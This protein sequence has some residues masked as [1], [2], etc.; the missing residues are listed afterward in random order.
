MVLDKEW[1]PTGGSEG[2]LFIHGLYHDLNDALKRFGQFLALGN[3]PK[4]IRPFVFNWPSAT[5]PLL[6]WCAH[7]QA[8]DNDTH[9]DFKRFLKCLEV[10]GI[11]IL[12][13][14][15]HSLGARFFLRSFATTKSIFSRQPG[16]FLGSMLSDESEE[17][18]Q[19][20]RAQPSGINTE[21][22]N[23]RRIEL[24]NLIFLNPEYEF[25]TFVHDY[26]DVKPYTQNITLYADSRDIAVKAS[27]T[28]TRQKNFGIA[29]IKSGFLGGKIDMDV[30]DTSDLD[31]NMNSQ[32]HGYFNINRVMVDDLWE[33][34][35]T[36]KRAS[37]R[38]SRL[39]RSNTGVYRFTLLP[40]S[41]VAI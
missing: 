22:V 33:L 37:E 39:K 21:P 6:Y 7:N 23:D 17:E 9:R 12:H 5:S 34:I 35:V 11:K 10:A 30:V 40:S 15:C 41:V 16:A 4:H 3:F 36:S 38:T 8:S 26:D 28:L 27:G 29:S 14:M 32:F 19:F 13:I 25:S 31:R 18:H 1:I 2:I 24:R 20:P